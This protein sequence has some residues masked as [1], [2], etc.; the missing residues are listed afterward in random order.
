MTTPHSSFHHLSDRDLLR[1]VTRLAACEREATACLIA[2]LAEVDGRRLYLGEGCASLFTYCVQVLRLSEH[3][4]YDRIEVARAV[5]RFPVILGQL[6]AGAVTLTTIRL[7]APHLTN[8][9]HAALLA[10]ARHRSRRKVE[11]IVARLHP[12][13]DVPS[14]VRKLPT[15]PKPDSPIASGASVDQDRADAEGTTGM[16]ASRFS[17]VPKPPAPAPTRPAVVAPLAPSRYKVSFT[18]SAETYAKLQEAQ[19][20]LRHVVPTGD[21]ALIFDRALTLLVTE[22]ARTTRAATDRPN[23]SGRP[24]AGS[25]HIPAAVKRTV[26]QR[27]GGQCAFV[28]SSGRRCAERSFLQ[29]HH[30]VPYAK[31]GEASV[32]NT[33]LRCRSHNLYEAEREFGL[34]QATRVREI[35]P[36]F[37]A[38]H[39]STRFETTPALVLCQSAVDTEHGVSTRDYGETARAGA[40]D[41]SP[42]SRSAIRTAGDGHH[43]HV[44]VW[45]RVVNDAKTREAKKPTA[46]PSP[47]IPRRGGLAS[48]GNMMPPAAAPVMRRAMPPSGLRCGSLRCVNQ[49]ISNPNQKLVKSAGPNIGPPRKT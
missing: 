6:A 35:A 4:A 32:E 15:P 46:S 42:R 19:A 40:A 25:R 22:C 41:A 11:Q 30:V 14:T 24:T 37:G 29:F 34:R 7:L 28:S 49:P 47:Y 45:S 23:P 39:Q 5:R 48:A 18:I 27:D 1:E 33:E 44:M 16:A 17:P 12:R 13:S 10:E 9:N 26:W 31:G 38:S 43:H 20:L 8:E 2:G 3:A 21:P 36:V